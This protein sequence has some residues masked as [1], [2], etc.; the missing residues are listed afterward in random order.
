MID[1]DALKLGLGEAIVIPA[2]IRNIIEA[3]LCFKMISIATKSKYEGIGLNG[4][5]GTYGLG[6]G[7]YSA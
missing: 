7:G 1:A 5:A 4:P 2:Q 3:K 6:S